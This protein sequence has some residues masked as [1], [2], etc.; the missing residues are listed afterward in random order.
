VYYTHDVIGGGS[1]RDQYRG[2]MRNNYFAFLLTDNMS[3]TRTAQKRRNKSYQKN[4]RNIKVRINYFAHKKE[5]QL[6]KKK[7]ESCILIRL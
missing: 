6:G 1:I 5:Q 7:N 2:S 3:G 4:I